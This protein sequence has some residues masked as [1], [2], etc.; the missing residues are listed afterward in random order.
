MSYKN[1]P[2]EECAAAA[3]K[4]IAD[5]ATI[6]Q[7]F[8]C[9]KCGSRQTISE[10]DKFFTTGKCEECGHVTNIA[11]SGCNYLIVAQG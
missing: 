10:P 1:F 4:L 2:I 9:G 5:G 8:T 3:E 11:M 7:K 6:Y